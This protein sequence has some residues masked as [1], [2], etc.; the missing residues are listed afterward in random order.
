M[1]KHACMVQ[2]FRSLT[3]FSPE[4]HSSLCPPREIPPSLS[5]CSLKTSEGGS[6]C[7]AWAGRGAGSGEIISIISA[8]HGPHDFLSEPVWICVP[9]LLRVLRASSVAGGEISGLKAGQFLYVLNR[10]A[11]PLGADHDR[12]NRN[13]KACRHTCRLEDLL[14]LPHPDLLLRVPK[15]NTY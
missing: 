6:Q 7:R 3:V 4:H 2:H 12:H 9:F 5:V 15:R 11:K 10:F 1:L 13:G 8:L 14:P